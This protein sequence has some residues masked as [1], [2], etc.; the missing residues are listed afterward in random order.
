MK[1]QLV[2]ILF[3]TVLIAACNKKDCSENEEFVEATVSL[4]EGSDC[5]Y[6]LY[7][8][9]DK[10][11]YAPINLPEKDKVWTG[12]ADFHH[13]FIKFRVLENDTLYCTGDEFNPGREHK[14]PKIEITAIRD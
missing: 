1:K 10:Q 14:I 4:Q 2:S 8:P 3:L 12:T 13:V 11:T 5:G 7:V 6:W 9:S